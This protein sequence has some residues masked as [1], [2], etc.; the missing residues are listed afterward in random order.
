MTG[1]ELTVGRRIEAT[2]TQVWSVVTDRDRAEQVLTG[3]SRVELMTD[4]PYA[5]ATR[6]RETRRMLGWEVTHEMWV[7]DNDPLRRT[8]VEASTRGTD[9]RTV[10]TLTPV[11]ERATELSVTFGAN[12]PD[13]GAV[14]K[15]AWRVAGRLGLRATRRAM[16]QDLDDIAAAA[17]ESRARTSG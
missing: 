8:V 9:Y 1:H 15:L 10:F 16:E 5:V 7:A 14:Q 3:V 12:T 4:G 11:G 6:W 17:A 13:P 2:P